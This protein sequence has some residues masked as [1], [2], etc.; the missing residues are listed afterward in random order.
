MQGPDIGILRSVQIES[1][2]FFE[3]MNVFSPPTLPK[4]SNKFHMLT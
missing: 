2:N 4:K 3:K 1:Y